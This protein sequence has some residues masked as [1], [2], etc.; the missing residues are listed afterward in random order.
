MKCDAFTLQ[1]YAH[2]PY[3]S[4]FH[5]CPAESGVEVVC[6]IKASCLALEI[7]ESWGENRRKWKSQQSPGVKP[8]TP[9]LSR[10]CSATEPQQPD[11]HQPQSLYVLHRWY[12]MPQSQPGIHDCLYVLHRWCW[13]PQSQL[14]IHNCEGWWLSSCH[15]SMAEHWRLKPEVFWVQLPA[16]AG[17][18][19]FLYF[20]LINSF[21]VAYMKYDFV[22]G[23]D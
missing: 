1:E 3:S 22:F 14:A 17:F 23:N 11:N 13:M 18:V 4:P 12:W 21:I 7:N 9:G 16:T 6:L 5:L 2:K 20:H 8:R 19:T 10:Q 15:D